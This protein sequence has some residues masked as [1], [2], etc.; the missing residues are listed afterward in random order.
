MSK[1]SLVAARFR[2]GLSTE[3]RKSRRAFNQAWGLGFMR[4]HRLTRFILSLR[5]FWGFSF[6]RVLSL[7]L[8]RLARLSYLTLTTAQADLSYS[9]RGGFWFINGARVNNPFLQVFVGDYFSPLTDPS[10]VSGG[11]GVLYDQVSL[12]RYHRYL[13]LQALVNS[14]LALAV[15]TPAFLEVDE[16]TTTASLLYE[17]RGGDLFLDP[18]VGAAPYLTIRMYNWKYTT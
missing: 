11:A 2:P 6:L 10:F 15:D 7:S 9:V 8:G 18:Q 14:P 12:F 13:Q 3:W 1:W 17:P 16:L 5:H 4:Q